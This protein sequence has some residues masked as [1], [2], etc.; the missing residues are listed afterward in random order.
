MPTSSRIYFSER[1]SGLVM[2]RIFIA[3]MVIFAFLFA[4]VAWAAPGDFDEPIPIRT[5]AELDGIRNNLH[6]YYILSEDIDLASYLEYPGEG[7]FKYGEAGWLPIGYSGSPFTGRLDGNGHK[8]TGLWINRVSGNYVGLFGYIQN[9]TITNLG[10]EIGIAGIKGYNYV[11]GLVAYQN[12]GSITNCYTT[13]DVSGSRWI[14]GLVASH[15]NS[16]IIN[17]YTTGNVTGTSDSVG[18]LVGSSSGGSITNSRATGSVSG[19]GNTGGLVGYISN[20]DIKNSNASG[21]I[22]STSTSVGG[23]V[24]QVAGGNITDSYATGNITGSRYSGGLVGYANTGTANIT[25]KNCYATGNVGNNFSPNR[26]IGGLVGYTYSNSRTITITDSHASGDVIGTY[27]VGG[28]LGYQESINQAANQNIENCYA[29]G[30]VTAT[31]DY[32]GG[33]VG[34]IY[35]HDGGTINTII[36]SYATGSV[37]TNGSY[38]GGLVGCSETSGNVVINNCYAKGNVK[39]DGNRVGGLVGLQYV[40]GGASNNIITNSY[41]TS[42]VIGASEVGG[43]VGMQYI[44]TAGNN[45]ILSCYVTGN[46]WAL[47]DI[48][49]G[50][51][52]GFQDIVGIGVNTLSNNYRYR[53]TLINGEPI[54]IDHIN[55]RHDRKHGGIKTAEEFM[56]KTT[57]TS[58]SWQFN[59]SVPTAGPWHWDEIGF[60]KLNIGTENFPFPWSIIVDPPVYRIVITPKVATIVVSEEKRLSAEVF[61]ENATDKSLIWESDNA[62]VAT[63]NNLGVVHGVSFG[64]A[65]ITGWS[66]SDPT[67]SDT[68]IVTVTDTIIDVEKIVISPKE[69]TII[70]GDSLIL[71]VTVMPENASNSRVTWESD[72]NLIATVNASGVVTAL[73]VE[74]VT[75][76]VRSVSNPDVMD[77]CIVTVISADDDIPVTDLKV[78]PNA[79][80]IEKFKTLALT[81][82]ITPEDATDKSVIWESANDLI[83]TVTSSG[84]VIALSEGTVTI[85]ATSVSNPDVKDTCIVTVTSECD[86]G[87][88]AMGNGYLVFA[89]FGAVQ[90][91]LRKRQ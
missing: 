24:G 36:S 70:K 64:T 15:N 73:S 76:T 26:E 34:R 54:P 89:L 20:S 32:A 67:V 43:I 52:V 63:V 21:N 88:N 7:W 30:S 27:Y 9:S 56:T 69:A 8:I 46:M 61:P 45:S 17:S 58:N 10:V 16:S 29:T 91:V 22:T 18:G 35:L 85:T 14:G 79:V 48:N 71:T 62:L 37:T 2:K 83:A 72:N 5:A 74:T 57:Y 75:I 31:S 50:A 66:K 12:S 1:G 4:S 84:L 60:P 33:L 68:C 90:F 47:N 77:T 49:I 13:G 41:A 38:V 81:P 3:F 11:G 19:V 59:D 65:R 86:I 78:Y 53:Y 39:A 6:F 55:S 23:L 82:E 28:L 51:I 40:N 44:G 42:N 25:I 87:C 80:T